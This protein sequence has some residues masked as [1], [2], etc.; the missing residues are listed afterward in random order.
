MSDFLY[1][2]IPTIPQQNESIHSFFKSP[3]ILEDVTKTSI[4][5]AILGGKING[6]A[7][8]ALVNGYSTNIMDHGHWRENCSKDF[9]GG[10][11]CL[12]SLYPCV[13][14]LV[15]WSGGRMNEWVNIKESKKISST[16]FSNL[17]PN[18]EEHVKYQILPNEP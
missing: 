10:L 8:L 16:E 3:I 9:V 6:E 14:V 18:I 13:S 4:G 17:F 15:H 12:L 2:S 7:Y 11:L 1:L 5:K